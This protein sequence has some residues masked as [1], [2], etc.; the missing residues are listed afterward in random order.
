[1]GTAGPPQEALIL[2]ALS[3]AGAIITVDNIILLLLYV[4]IHVVIGTDES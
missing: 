3:I 2:G 4:F 1:M